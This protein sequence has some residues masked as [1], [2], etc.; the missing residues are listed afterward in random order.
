M[1]KQAHNN[2][3]DTFNLTAGHVVN[4]DQIETVKFAQSARQSMHDHSL[5]Y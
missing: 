2:I 4:P 1:R 3:T 5:K